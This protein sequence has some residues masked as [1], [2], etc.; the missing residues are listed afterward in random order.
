MDTLSAAGP[1]PVDRI[2]AMVF[3]PIDSQLMT[4]QNL[5]LWNSMWNEASTNVSL[6]EMS[7]R[8]EAERLD[9]QLSLFEDAKELISGTNW[10][11]KTAAHTLETMAEGIWV[12]LYYSPDYI[13]VY[14]A[15]M[16]MGT[17]LS[18]VFPSRTNEIMKRAS[19]CPDS[20]R[21]P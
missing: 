8:Y 18:M 21:G 6:A 13:T 2:I 3:G 4:P 19:N 7:E 10:T 9:V 15:R 12:R 5:K 1:D 17:V 11:P 14:D 16:A 20:W